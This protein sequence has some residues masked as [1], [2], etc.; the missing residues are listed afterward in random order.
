LYLGSVFFF[1]FPYPFNFDDF[2]RSLGARFYDLFSHKFVSQNLLFLHIFI[3]KFINFF[4]IQ[5]QIDRFSPNHQNWTGLVLL[6][7]TK[8]KQTTLSVTIHV[9]LYL[10]TKPATATATH[11]EACPY[12]TAASA[13]VASF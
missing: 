1:I 12:L 7:F 11:C 5:I 9:H 6:I 4:K 8:T 3:S 10:D 2:Y 13:R